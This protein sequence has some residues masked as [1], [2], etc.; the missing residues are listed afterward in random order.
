VSPIVIL[1]AIPDELISDC[2]SG[3]NVIYTGIGK[4]NAAYWATKVILE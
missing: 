3:I 2:I 4:I 1:A